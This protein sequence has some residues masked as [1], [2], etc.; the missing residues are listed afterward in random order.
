M[1][2][3]IY[4]TFSDL[5]KPQIA[6]IKSKYE[7]LCEKGSKITSGL[8]K[9]KISKSTLFVETLNSLS[10]SNQIEFALNHL[11]NKIDKI[12]EYNLAN[13][14]LSIQLSFKGHFNE[15]QIDSNTI[16]LL[17]KFK[18][19]IELDFLLEFTEVRN[20]K[21]LPPSKSTGLIIKKIWR[22][23]SSL[24]SNTR[25]AAKAMA[26]L[27]DPGTIKFPKRKSLI[28]KVTKKK[29][30]SKKKAMPK[31]KNNPKVSFKAKRKFGIKKFSAKKR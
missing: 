7:V 13:I 14:S 8:L 11:L 16:N 4:T 27:S 24:P 2:E 31:K 29:A 3:I 25:V 30:A 19:P 6:S 22:R 1:I 9:S 12:Y 10:S 18:I 20:L 21:A 17:N 23:P 5:T 28:S 15:L 26:N